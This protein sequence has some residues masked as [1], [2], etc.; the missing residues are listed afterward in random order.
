MHL[1]LTPKHVGHNSCS[2]SCSVLFPP[3]P[4]PKHCQLPLRAPTGLPTW[5]NWSGP[6]DGRTPTAKR[7]HSEYPRVS[8]TLSHSLSRSE[9]FST[10]LPQAPV[11]QTFVHSLGLYSINYQFSCHFKT[12]FECL[13]WQSTRN[14]QFLWGAKHKHI[15]LHLQALPL[16]GHL[17]PACKHASVSPTVEKKQILHFVYLSNHFVSLIYLTNFSK[18]QRM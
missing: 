12:S 5:P 9:N 14:S 11:I 15:F 16:H 2:L 1:L 10:L 18:F 4:T 6:S 8:L 3:C 17:A 7:L 13:F